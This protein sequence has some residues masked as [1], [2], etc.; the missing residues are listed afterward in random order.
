MN[1]KKFLLIGVGW[2]FG[3][4]VGLALTVG[5]F[6]WYEAKPK[7]PQPPKPWNTSAIKAEY[8]GVDAE[9]DKNTIEFISTLNITEFDYHVTDENQVSLSG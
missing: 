1:W 4:A 9:G 6:L 2:G 5:V 3:T 8:D 7:T